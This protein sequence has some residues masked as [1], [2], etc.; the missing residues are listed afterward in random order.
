MYALIFSAFHVTLIILC[1]ALMCFTERDSLE[2]MLTK[3]GTITQ[4]ANKTIPAEPSREPAPDSSQPKSR[5]P[6]ARPDRD[7]TAR[8]PKSTLVRQDAKGGAKKKK[9]ENGAMVPR[10][11]GAEVELI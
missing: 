10:Q 3:T 2:V 4:T 5:R 9:K 6:S 11:N 8:E 1:C 7:D